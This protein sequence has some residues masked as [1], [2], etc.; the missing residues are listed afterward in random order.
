MTKHYTSAP[1]RES[2]GILTTRDACCLIIYGTIWKHER[3][4]F[5]NKYKGRE[6]NKLDFESE[7]L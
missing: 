4:V 1:E 6:E 7:W 3:K 2:R 5:T